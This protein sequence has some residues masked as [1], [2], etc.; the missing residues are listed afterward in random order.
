M[1][2]VYGSLLCAAVGDAMSIAAETKTT[3]AIMEDYNGYIREILPC[4]EDGYLPG[5]GHPLYMVGADFSSGYFVAQSALK[6]GGVTPDSVKDGLL[7]WAAHPEYKKFVGPN[8]EK[9]IAQLQGTVFP[10][11]KQDRV[12]CF[13][14]GASSGGAM[15]AGIL[16]LFAKDEDALIADVITLCMPTHNNDTSIG[17]ACA[18]AGAVREALQDTADVY[19]IIDAALKCGQKGFLAAAQTPGIR[20]SAGPCLETRIAFAT[21]LGIRYKGNFDAALT[22]LSDMVG[23]TIYAIDAVPAALGCLAATDNAFD[24][25]T[26]AVN[27]GDDCSTAATIVGYIA[28]ALYG[29]DSRFEKY[30]APIQEVNG[31]DFQSVCKGIGQGGKK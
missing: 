9:G 11:N 1:D 14:R 3:A 2:R 29:P 16:G 12:A 18:V 27:M 31:F 19:S 25:V 20:T 30:A 17:A 6:A 24:A 13:N 22:E 8:S 4:K 28:G 26:M 10:E 21:K 15:R 23:T 5:V 7:A